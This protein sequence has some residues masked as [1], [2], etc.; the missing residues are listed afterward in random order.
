MDTEASSNAPYEDG[1][2]Y[3][4]KVTDQLLSRNN[5]GEVQII[6]GVKIQARLKNSKNPSDGTEACPQLQRD[7]RITIVEDDFERLTMAIRDLERLGFTD[8]DVSRLHPDNPQFFSL[9]EQAVYVR[10]KE[11]NGNEYWNLAG[12]NER[13]RPVALDEMKD[14]AT[15][16]KS[17]IAA[18]R[19]RMREGRPRRS[20]QSARPP[21]RRPGRSDQ[22]AGAPDATTPPPT[23][24][25]ES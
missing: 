20:G 7:V 9:L 16:L 22:T 15:T 11:H 17:R 8:D 25:T 6:L 10:M 23:S 3:R 2:V 5:N 4:A 21:S 12:V 18:A 24:P 13:P 14:S 19:Q 1:K